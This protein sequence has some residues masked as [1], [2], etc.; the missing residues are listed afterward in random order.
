MKLTRSQMLLLLAL[1]TVLAYA[2][3]THNAFLW[4]DHALITNNSY[5]RNQHYFPLAFHSDLFH[6]HSAGSVRYYRPLQTITY[7]ADYALWGLTPSGYHFTNLLLHLAGVLLLAMLLEEL[8]V[9]RLLAFA[10]AALF[11]VHPILTN[12]VTYVAGRADPLAFAAMLAAWLLWL[13]RRPL[14]FAASTLCFLAA[15]CSRENAFIF[16]L[17]ILLHSLVLNRNN[18]RRALL[19]ALPF[20]LLTAAFA[21]WRHTVLSLHETA[22]P[23]MWA[24]PWTVRLQIPFRALATY[25][26]LLVWP[27]HLQMERQVV[28]G[29]GW[30]YVLT[31]AGVLAAA[32]LVV[33]ARRN[34]LACFGV[35]WF[36]ITLLPVSGLLSLNATVAE[37]WL[38]VPCVGLFLAVVAV[39]PLTRTTMIAGGVALAALTART[40]VR[41]RDWRDAMTFYT[42]TKGAAP[43]S[44]AVRS[45]LG[46]EYVA[47][48][49]TNG[50]LSEL[51]AAERLAPDSIHAR[52]NLAALYLKQGDLAQAQGKAADALQLDPQNPGALMRVAMIWEQRGDFCKARLYYLRAMAQ[53]LSVPLRL[54]YGQFLLRQRR[55]AEAL[56]IAEEACAMEPPNAEAHNLRGAVLADSGRLDE[57]QAA[58]EMARTLD[59]HSPNAARN[60]TRLRA[61]REKRS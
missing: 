10:V 9:N 36:A 7:M 47:A 27:A 54:E 4:D 38:Y 51:L 16:P 20:A 41:N 40:I 42:C 14:P 48:G 19:D 52:E 15:L 49:Q 8:T 3:T 21:F 58:F 35:C 44:A 31:T 24:V 50:A 32:G 53:T 60:L 30:L 17:L 39:V 5:I 22:S 13:R 18:W 25:L 56:R 61:L 2:N 43:Y 12:A 45:N 26:G 28:L 6:N 23:A 1:L 34:R 46:L 59:R 57:A 55:H 11:A 37:H 33:L 29:G